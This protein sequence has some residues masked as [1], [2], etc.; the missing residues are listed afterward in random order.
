MSK[1]DITP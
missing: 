1:F